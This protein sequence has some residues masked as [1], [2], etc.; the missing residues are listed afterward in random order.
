MSN[1]ITN[2]NAKDL[3][4]RLSE[5]IGVSKELKFLVGFFYFSGISE[6]Y[7]SLKANPDVELKILVGLDVDFLNR[8]LVE[9]AYRSNQS[10]EAKLNGFFNSIRKSINSDS[11]DSKE[12]YEQVRFFINLIQNDKLLIRKTYNPNHAKLY[13]FKFNNHQVI[14]KNLFI[15]G[16]SNLTRRGISTQEEFNVEISDYGFN[17]AEKY[18]DELWE[19]A[20]KINEV[21]LA[22][23]KLIEI[24]E[25]ETLIKEITPFEAYCLILKSFLDTFE[26]KSLKTYVV[27][28][29][30]KNGYK[31][32]RYQTDAVS[33]ALAIIE[34]HNG[35]LI[36]DVVGLG[37]TIIACT[38]AKQ[39]GKRGVVIC[40][41]G[42]MGDK[43]KTEGWTKYLEQFEL[44]DW[45]VRSVGDLESTLE[46]VKGNPD[47]EVIIVD[48][49][50]RFRNQDTQ[51]YELLMNICRGRKVI[52]LTATPYNNKPGDVLALL[53]LFITPKKSGITLDN[54]LEDKFQEIEIVFKK[55]G[56]I[57]KHYN[58]NDI[59]KRK[60]AEYYYRQIFK[61]LPIDLS[62]V[63]AKAHTLARQ[64]REIIEP[65]TIRRN[66]LDLIKNIN[67][68]NEVNE[69]SKVENPMEWFYGLTPDQLTFYDT[70]VNYFFAPPDEGGFFKGAIYQPYRYEK[71]TD[72]LLDEEQ[73]TLESHREQIQQQ[74]LYDIMRRMLVKRFESSFGAFSKSID[75]FISITEKVLEFIYKTGNNDP[76]K[77]EYIL[78]RDLMEKLLELSDDEVEEKLIEY[79]TQIALGV[80]P[81]KHKR[82]RIQNFARGREFIED[83][84]SDLELFRRIS[85]KLNHLK[86]VE[87]D[88]KAECLIE[89]IS[90]IINDKPSPKEPKRKVIIFSEYAD[91][92]KHLEERLGKINPTLAERTLVVSGNLP[93]NTISVINKNFDASAKIQAN[94]YDILICTD[95]LSE[96]FNL[97]RAGMIVNYDIPWNP[98]RVIQRL[99]RINRI[100]K[101]VFEKLYIVNFFPTEKG[102]EYVRSREIAQGK[103]FIIHN[104][105]GEDAKIFDIDEEPT[106]S[107][108]YDKLTQNPE[109]TDEESFYTK[110]LNLFESV[111]NEHP[112]IVEKL[113]NMPIRVK[114][115][116][117][118]DQNK[119]FVFFRKNKL[120]VKSAFRDDGKILVED[121]SL[122]LVL[123]QI[124]CTPDTKPLPIS[125]EFWSIYQAVKEIKEKS[126]SSIPATSITSK[127]LNKIDLLLRNATTNL[128]YNLRAFLTMLREDITDY[129]TLPNYTLRRI[130]NLSHSNT[131][132]LVKELQTLC[133]ELGEN[134]LEDIKNR[135]EPTKEIIVAVY[136]TIE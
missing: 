55:L 91:T 13:L 11:F 19:K 100:S 25:N 134:Y 94:D 17:D 14:R 34:N 73:Q 128:P 37:K 39:L 67:Y 6:L 135:P 84:K 102:A 124:A 86:L 15:T 71:K 64:I 122:E 32:Y 81:R 3:K 87:N 120:Y 21:E 40:P 27:E 93:E 44:Y 63:K 89:E 110:V 54:N 69:L 8:D 62:K 104:T 118:F 49:A 127:A 126:S 78:D 136:N 116:K 92:V 30:K 101:K 75:N 112:Q 72:V 57:R 107:G 79:E 1:F 46:L 10:D 65:V 119:M 97:N 115:A 22:K 50:H 95:K 99:G 98:V 20:V 31:Q 68:R 52:L 24:I 123:D 4:E 66:R 77:G 12:F 23:K 26:H 61:Q 74:N 132:K 36:A 114:V 131:D 2:S 42:L 83:I 28:L 82:Y 29:L 133:N 108:L 38:I 43:N 51:N 111:K 113:N 117:P 88:P 130:S 48:E 80:Y 35:V 56:Y 45:E 85:Q 60:R 16:S 106:P 129:G 103:M 33:Q 76:L 90:K 47:F 125:D 53:K 9:H 59:D 121:S 96:G 7:D 105:L 109:N 70:V 5:I 41:P 18:F 58:S